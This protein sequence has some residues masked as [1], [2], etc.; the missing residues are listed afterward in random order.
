MCAASRLT[1]SRA[2]RSRTSRPSWRQ[3]SGADPRR[4]IGPASIRR[5]SSAARA[6][7]VS[8][9]RPPSASRS[10]SARRRSACRIAATRRETCSRSQVFAMIRRIRGR[11]AGALNPCSSQSI[12]GQSSSQPA[13]TRGGLRSAGAASTTSIDT[14]RVAGQRRNPTRPRASAQQVGRLA[15]LSPPAFRLSGIA[16]PP[17]TQQ[18]PASANR[19]CRF[20]PRLRCHDGAEPHR[21]RAQA[22]SSDMR[23]MHETARR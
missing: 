6:R 18:G 10:A 2:A 5:C 21:R 13:R 4:S 12:G 22:V 14:R 23:P 15:G 9:P 20:A 1:A 16:P 17:A 3:R 7:A 19:W 11:G 8:V